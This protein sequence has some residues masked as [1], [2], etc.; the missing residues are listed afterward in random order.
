[1]A[2]VRSPSCV[3][4]AWTL[5][6]VEEWWSPREAKCSDFSRSLAD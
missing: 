5:I 1:M 6:A 2:T 4:L 3:I